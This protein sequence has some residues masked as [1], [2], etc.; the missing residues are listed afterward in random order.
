MVLLDERTTNTSQN[1]VRCYGQAMR[2][3]PLAAIA[4]ASCT[5]APAAVP[6]AANTPSTRGRCRDNEAGLR[7]ALPCRNQAT[8]AAQAVAASARMRRRVALLIRWRWMLNVL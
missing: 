5:A 7:S 2:L 1:G 6:V 8:A 4:L 3:A